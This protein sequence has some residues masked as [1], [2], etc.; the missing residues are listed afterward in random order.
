VAG[1]L[2][3]ATHEVPTVPGRRERSCASSTETADN[4]KPVVCEGGFRIPQIVLK[5]AK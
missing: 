3:R 2:A 5:E 1:D 4:K